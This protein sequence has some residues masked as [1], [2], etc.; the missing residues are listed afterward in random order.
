[1]MKRNLGSALRAKSHW[2]RCRDLFL[3][4]L[5]HNIAIVLLAVFYRA[6][7]TPFLVPNKSRSYAQAFLLNPLGHFNAF[8]EV[9]THCA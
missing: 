8:I 5:T 9:R 7:V 2:G 6:V 3:R 4:V 1:M